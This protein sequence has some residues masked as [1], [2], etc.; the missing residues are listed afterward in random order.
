MVIWIDFFIIAGLTEVIKFLS[1]IT[2]IGVIILYIRW[3]LGKKEGAT[4]GR[5]ETNERKFK[6][7]GSGVCEVK[8]V[9]MGEIKASFL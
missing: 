5:V 2:L 4:Q 9:S 1:V 7:T 8:R 3:H 6:I